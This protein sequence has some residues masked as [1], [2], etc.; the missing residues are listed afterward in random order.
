ML[1]ANQKTLDDM[2][3]RYPGIVAS[4]MAFENLELP[5]CPH[6]A[7]DNT[8]EVQVG[9]MGR[10]IY[11]VGATTKAKLV[12]NVVNKLGEYF[13]NECKKFFDPPALT[14]AAS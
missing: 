5:P 7:S 6:C 12:S 4:I 9:M 13:C 14:G 3:R 11:I 2:E 10:T 8:A 1:Q